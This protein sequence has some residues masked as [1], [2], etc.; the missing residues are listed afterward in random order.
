VAWPRAAGGGA[1]AE[2]AQDPGD[3]KDSSEGPDTERDDLI[4]ATASA[5]DHE[6]TEDLEWTRR[7]LREA[8]GGGLFGGPAEQQMQEPT[9]QAPGERG[10]GTAVVGDAVEAEAATS[11]AGHRNDPCYSNW[12]REDELEIESV[13]VSRFRLG[14]A[15]LDGGSPGASETFVTLGSPDGG[16]CRPQEVDPADAGGCRVYYFPTGM[17]R[18]RRKLVHHVAGNLGLEHWP[19]GKR[20]GGKTVAVAIPGTR[21]RLAPP[22]PALTE[23]LPY[24]RKGA[25]GRSSSGLETTK[26]PQHLFHLTSPLDT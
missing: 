11:G 16:G 23:P 25:R 21:R 19:H 5:V 20:Q 17:G 3:E 4:A 1:A 9:P 8:L 24:S 12:T 2:A 10:S 6:A 15:R 14:G 7:Y 13:L 18:V 22:P 26:P